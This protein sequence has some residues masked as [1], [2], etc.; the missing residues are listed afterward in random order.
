MGASALQRLAAQA[1]IPV[2][3]PL[4]GVYDFSTKGVSMPSTWRSGCMRCRRAR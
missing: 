3:E 1:G 4:T 2:V